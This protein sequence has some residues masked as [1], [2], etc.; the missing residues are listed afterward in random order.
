MSFFIWL[1][2]LALLLAFCSRVI[3]YLLGGSSAA[4]SHDSPVENGKPQRR[5]FQFGLRKLMLWTAVWSVYL[6]FVQWTGIPPPAAVVFTI[7][8]TVILAIRSRWGYERGSLIA[9][10]G[11]GILAACSSIGGRSVAE[12]ILVPFCA[13]FWSRS[14]A[15]RL[16]DCSRR[17]ACCGFDRQR[18]ANE[19]AAG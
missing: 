17:G 13:L 9:A 6:G 1:A 3:D 10:F 14:R 16:Y 4:Q 15:V 2:T 5:H 19:D 7:Y 8:L 18:D 11:T 12:F